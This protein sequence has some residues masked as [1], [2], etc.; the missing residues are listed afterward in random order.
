[1]FRKITAIVTAIAATAMLAIAASPASAI[2]RSYEPMDADE[3]VIER[4]AQRDDTAQ[5]GCTVTL[6]NPNGSPGQSVT[7]PHG[8]SFSVKN[9]ATGKTHTYTCNN[10][11]W[12]ETVS[13]TNPTVEHTYEAEK[14]Y[15]D[16]SGTVQ[17]VDLHEYTYSSGG[18]YAAP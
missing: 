6:Q 3:P 10:G 11:Q 1:M 15:V 2:Y 9:T 5:K 4:T 16:G 12:E 7:Y 14:A 13:F 18:Y 17:V 8:Y